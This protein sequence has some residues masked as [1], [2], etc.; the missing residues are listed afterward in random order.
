MQ[1]SL[2]SLIFFMVAAFAAAQEVPTVFFGFS[3]I[4]DNLEASDCNSDYDSCSTTIKQSVAGVL[5]AVNFNNVASVKFTAVSNNGG[6][7]SRI[8]TTSNPQTTVYYTVNVQSATETYTSLTDSLKIAIDD[9]SF[10]TLM[11]SNGGSNAL[12][13]ASALSQASGGQQSAQNKLV[14]RPVSKKLTGTMIACL[15]IGIV[16]FVAILGFVVAF[17]MQAKSA[18]AAYLA[19]NARP[20]STA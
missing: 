6:S 20:V 10:T 12:S 16:L 11:N 15:V 14:K 13:S 7:S 17:A 9:G 5:A 3:H 18:E 2:A 4:L 1:L 19:A 8:M